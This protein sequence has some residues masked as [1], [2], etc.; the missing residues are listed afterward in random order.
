[1][2]QNTENK[3]LNVFIMIT[4]TFPH[5]NTLINIKELGEKLIFRL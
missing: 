4:I 5:I 1:M 3:H 2:L